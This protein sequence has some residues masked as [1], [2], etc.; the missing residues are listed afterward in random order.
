M[1]VSVIKSGSE[2]FVDTPYNSR[3][4]KAAKDMGGKWNG[5]NWKFDARDEQR[6]R[7]LCMATYGSDGVTSDLVTLRITLGPGDGEYAG[8]VELHGRTIARAL[9]RDSGA[10]LGDGV[11]LLEGG[12]SSG[13]SV[14]NWRT[15]VKEGTTVLVRD[16]PRIP[17]EALVAD[18]DRTAQIEQ[19]APVV[20]HTALREERERLVNRLAEIDAVLALD[21]IRSEK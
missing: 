14:K 5:G 17:A 1:K 11:V 4:V 7:E 13:G 18:G 21:N 2:L 9:G 6:V 12:F 3:F 8:P 20:D 19:E 16:F 15:T 10:K